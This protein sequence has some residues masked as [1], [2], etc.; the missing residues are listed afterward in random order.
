MRIMNKVILIL[1]VTLLLFTACKEQKSVSPKEVNV[2]NETVTKPINDELGMQFKRIRNCSSI[3]FLTLSMSREGKDKY[4]HWTKLG[5]SKINKAD[6]DV[7]LKNLRK[8]YEKG[9]DVNYVIECFNPRHVLLGEDSK[10]RIDF[11]V[12]FECEKL[13][14][15]SDGKTEYYTIISPRDTFDKMASKYN[16]KVEK[17]E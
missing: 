13:Y 9:K 7:L 15:T 8:A 14:V 5:E 4:T 3:K 6:L 17:S 1:S 2:P 12:C 11:Q 16:L 10:G